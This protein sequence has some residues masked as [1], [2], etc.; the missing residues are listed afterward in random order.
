VAP[1]A[2]LLGL[3]ESCAVAGADRLVGVALGSLLGDASPL[4]ALISGKGSFCRTSF[5][6]VRYGPPRQLRS[7]SFG[8]VAVQGNLTV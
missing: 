5:C 7:G 6:G 3:A 2:K 4:P 8:T 1:E